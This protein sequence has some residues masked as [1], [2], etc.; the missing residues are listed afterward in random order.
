MSDLQMSTLNL[1]LLN[2]GLAR[3]FVHCQKCMLHP[4]HYIS[5]LHY[6][7]KF[8]SVVL[9]H[10]LGIRSIALDL[11]VS[12]CKL[13]SHEKYIKYVISNT[14]LEYILQFFSFLTE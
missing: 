9:T 6:I 10:H 1:L 4:F 7:P 2:G 13:Y 12:Q 14:V 3:C 8:V 5:T 11:A